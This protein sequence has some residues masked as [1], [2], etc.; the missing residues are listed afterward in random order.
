MA[1]HPEKP[2]DMASTA[3]VCWTKSNIEGIQKGETIPANSPL[4][5]SPNG[6]AFL[7]IEA[8]P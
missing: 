2:K 5:L 1:S 8:S 4:E 3:R 6:G 7:L